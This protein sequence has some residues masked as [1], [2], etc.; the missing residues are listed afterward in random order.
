MTRDNI[1]SMRNCQNLVSRKARQTTAHITS[2]RVTTI[3]S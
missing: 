3:G 2:Y 1:V